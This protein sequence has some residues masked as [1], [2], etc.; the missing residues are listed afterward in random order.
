MAPPSTNPSSWLVSNLLSRGGRSSLRVWSDKG[1]W[2]FGQPS[3]DEVRGLQ[4]WVCSRVFHKEGVK[5]W[6]EWVASPKWIKLCK[7][8]VRNRRCFFRTIPHDRI[9]WVIVPFF[10]VFFHVFSP[11]GRR[12]LRALDPAWLHARTAEPRPSAAIGDGLWESFGAGT[13][14]KVTRKSRGLGWKCGI[15]DVG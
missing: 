12:L 2:S 5:F 8:C 11:P 1:L 3:S 14:G 15:C 10:H 9:D 4:P 13:A 7:F 6:E